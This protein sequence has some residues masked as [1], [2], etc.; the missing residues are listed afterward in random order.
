MPIKGKRGDT[1]IEVL[2]AI[3]VFALVS[4]LSIIVMNSGVATVEATLELSMARNEIDAQSEALRYIHNSFL[5]EREF[6]NDELGQPYANIWKELKKNINSADSDAILPL[7]I[8]DCKTRYEGT[9]SENIFSRKTII[10]NTRKLDPTNPKNTIISVDSLNAKDIFQ[11]TQLNPRLIFN[12]SATTTSEDNTDTKL[13]ESEYF[14]N[15]KSAEGIWIIPIASS[16]NLD[17]SP[18]FYDFHIYTC[19]I[20]P[21]RDYPT[22]IGT[23][24]RLY[25]PELIEESK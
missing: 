25:N 18:E 9:S 21:G 10:L 16:P 3:A 7:S 14:T 5:S 15:L 1:M 20:A 8:N 13:Y 4:V 12:N 24:M 19:W 17:G 6:V 2:F 11:P 23:I 22:T